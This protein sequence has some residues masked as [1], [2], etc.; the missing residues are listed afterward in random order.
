[1]EGGRPIR[2]VVSL[3]DEPWSAHLDPSGLVLSSPLSAAARAASLSHLCALPRPGEVAASVTCVPS[4]GLARWWE[5]HQTWG[6]ACLKVL[7]TWW[8]ARQNLHA[9]WQPQAGLSGAGTRRGHSALVPKHIRMSPPLPPP[10]QSHSVLKSC[11][12]LWHP[13]LC[14]LRL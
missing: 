11:L 2:Q 4:P 8:H 3:R 13:R 14:L 5:G 12:P 9:Q 1:M 6:T 10:P 7:R